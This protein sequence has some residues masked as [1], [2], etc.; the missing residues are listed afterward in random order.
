MA[1]DPNL[2]TFYYADRIMPVASSDVVIVALGKVSSQPWRPAVKDSILDV[3][4]N[5]WQTVTGSK[6][7]L[8]LNSQEAWPGVA[9]V[10]RDIKRRFP[11]R[12]SWDFPPSSFHPD[13]WRDP[14]FPNVPLQM[15]LDDVGFTPS[16]LVFPL[17][18]TTGEIV[19]TWDRPPLAMFDYATFRKVTDYLEYLADRYSYLSS[20]R[21]P[22]LELKLWRMGAPE[23][24]RAPDAPG[25]AFPHVGHYSLGCACQFSRRAEAHT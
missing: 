3:E 9:I 10:Q 14:L 5:I 1:Q 17:T 24:V 2:V 12:Q 7:E 13:V 15:E 21:P 25:A 22:H 19:T 8:W 23:H 18:H 6:G 20:I 11:N 16:K 4:I